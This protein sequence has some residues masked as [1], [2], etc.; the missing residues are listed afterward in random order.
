MNYKVQEYI[1]K[2]FEEINKDTPVMKAYELGY[3]VGILKAYKSLK[4]VDKELAEV[5]HKKIDWDGRLAT[6]IRTLITLENEEVVTKMD[7]IKEFLHD[8]YQSEK[9][10]DEDIK[11]LENFSEFLYKNNE[12]NMGII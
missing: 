2:K 7:K 9:F 12:I 11:F 6:I 8:K 10:S 1:N 3:A 5:F 4:A